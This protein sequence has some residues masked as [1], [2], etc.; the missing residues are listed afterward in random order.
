MPHA[1]RARIAAA[2][3]LAALALP[4]TPATAGSGSIP[5]RCQISNAETYRSVDRD[6]NQAITP[7]EYRA[8][9]DQ[10]GG[11]GLREDSTRDLQVKGT[12]ERYDPN[13]DGRITPQEASTMQL[14]EPAPGGV[15]T[16]H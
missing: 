9:L 12:F 1:G 10:V 2:T 16:G 7:D 15:T 6:G 4:G 14:E 13:R 11:S 5:Q 8:C 3:T